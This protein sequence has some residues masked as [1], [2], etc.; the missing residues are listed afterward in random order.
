MATL[1]QRIFGDRMVHSVSPVPLET[2]MAILVP[3]VTLK[4]DS[5]KEV[6]AL[7][8]DFGNYFQASA[9]AVA[10]AGMGIYGTP[11]TIDRHQGESTDTYH[12]TFPEVKAVYHVQGIIKAHTGS[13]GSRF[14]SGISATFQ[15]QQQEVD[16]GKAGKLL[17]TMLETHYLNYIENSPERFGVFLRQGEQEIRS[18]VPLL[19]S[20]GIVPREA[21]ELKSIMYFAWHRRVLFPPEELVKMGYTLDEAGMDRMP[22]PASFV[23]KNRDPLVS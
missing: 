8:C 7:K 12:F 13:G 18:G 16:L 6:G 15:L 2:L 17:S 1:W 21:A 14:Q 19:Q 22:S 5:F 11:L 3:K 10:Q 23:V 20:F 4:D 9:F